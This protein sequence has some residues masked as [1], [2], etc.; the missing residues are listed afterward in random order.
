M[1]LG[2]IHIFISLDSFIQE[3][4]KLPQSQIMKEF[5][6]FMNLWYHP[7]LLED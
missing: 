6:C 3:N 1:T 4:K 5:N 7:K 2:L